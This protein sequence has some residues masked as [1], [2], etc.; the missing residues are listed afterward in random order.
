MCW[1]GA[2]EDL[3]RKNLRGIETR[4][5]FH[6]LGNVVLSWGVLLHFRKK[7]SL[8]P[9]KMIWHSFHNQLH[10]DFEMQLKCNYNVNR[11]SLKMFPKSLWL[12]QNG[13]WDQILASLI[14]P[15]RPH[16]TRWVHKRFI[17]W[18]VII[19]GDH[20]ADNTGLLS[21]IISMLDLNHDT[22][23]EM[24]WVAISY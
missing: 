22:L 18:L 7:K 9:L 13:K 17:M 21:V 14:S 16:P 23:N 1:V 5:L 19:T 6:C 20:P 2:A 11:V 4:F 24:D 3:P 10:L 12:T 8:V 15:S